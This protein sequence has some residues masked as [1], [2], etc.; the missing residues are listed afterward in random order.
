MRN[1]LMDSP[2]YVGSHMLAYRN[3]ETYPLAFYSKSKI[4]ERLW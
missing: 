3:G 2:F 4:K 1:D